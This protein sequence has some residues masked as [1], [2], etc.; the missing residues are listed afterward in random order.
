MIN[1]DSLTKLLLTCLAISCSF[2][3]TP[4]R[5]GMVKAD[6]SGIYALVFGSD[7]LP[8]NLA[9][10]PLLK[11]PLVDG[12]RYRSVWQAIQPDSGSE[13]KWTQLDSQIAIAAAAGKKIGL[14]ISAGL[15]TPD[16]VYSTPP[17]VYKY[18]MQERDPVTGE[19]VGDQ[20]LPWDTA[21]QA[22]WLNF[23]A[24][25]GDRYDGNPTISYIVLSGFMESF[26]M[27]FVKTMGDDAAVNA[28][29]QNPPAGYPGLTT[30][31]TDSSAAYIPAAQKI[32]DAFMKAFPNTSVILTIDHPFPTDIGTTDEQTIKNSALAQYPGRFGTMVSALYA[33]PAPH[34]PPGPPLSYPK[35][36]QM[37]CRATDAARLYKDPDPVPIPAAPIPL[38]DALEHGVTLNG[39][40]VEIYDDDLL[41]P[42]NQAVV[43]FERKKLLANA[44]DSGT[45]STPVNL[46][47][48]H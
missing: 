34:T 32:I 41:D 18:K 30:R 5:A 10:N 1:R 47:I 42:D 25:L 20:P 12:F 45:P 9:G 3:A 19:L 23:V 38:Q 44:G 27:T 35:G 33:T 26:P 15:A 7:G 48:T 46:R 24:A 22:K 16:W 8:A 43:A 21:Y 29:A 11:N 6:P 36:F 28:L 40:Y 4:S 17:V 31:Y 39:K 14:S 2:S 37:V 13:Y